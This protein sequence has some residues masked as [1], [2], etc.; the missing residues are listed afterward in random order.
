VRSRTWQL[1]IFFEI[2]ALRGRKIVVEYHVSTSCRRQKSANSPLALADECAGFSDSFF[3]GVADH[4]APAVAA[5][6][7]FGERIAHV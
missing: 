5:A 2:A 6:T 4:F 7:E 3:A 1:K